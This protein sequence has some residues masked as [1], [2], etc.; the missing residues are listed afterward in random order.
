MMELAGGKTTSRRETS[1]D[2]IVE[3]VQVNSLKEACVQRLEGLILSGELAVGARLPPERRL[4]EMLDVSR[5]VVHQAL[6]ELAAR[7]L[8]DIAPRRGVF[9]N[10]FRTNGS[11]AL[12]NSLLSYHEG[13]LDP[14][15]RQSMIEVRMLIETETARLAA[16]HRSEE[17]L[18]TLAAIVEEEAHAARED[19]S[20]LIALD[21]AYHLHVALASGNAMYPL[22]LNSFREVYT[23]LTGQFFRRCGAGSTLDEVLDY[24]RRLLEALAGQDGEQA[25]AVMQSMLRH[26]AERLL[27]LDA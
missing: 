22:I 19:A 11:I 9:V 20:R 27:A 17:D 26:G 1:M 21:F 16:Q 8:V 10:D 25:A 23:N 12:L 13:D 6:V 3:P 7:G 24:H 5:P 14:H 4:A 15:L 18:R 2:L